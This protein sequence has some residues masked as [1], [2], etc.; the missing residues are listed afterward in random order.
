M[1]AQATEVIRFDE[2]REYFELGM[3]DSYKDT[4]KVL[5]NAYKEWLAEVPVT[6]FFTTDGSH[7]GLGVMGEKPIGSNPQTDRLYY[8][9]TKTYTLKTYGMALVM[10]YEVMRWDLFKTFTP[11][12]KE[13]AKTAI[14]RYDLVAYGLWNNAFSTADSVYTNYNSEAICST[15][16]ARM[17]SG[18]WKNRPTTDI[19]LSTTALQTATTDIRKTVNNRGKFVILT[20]RLLITTVENEWLAKILLQSEY[21]PD[22][23]NMQASPLRSYG[24]KLHTSPYITTSTYWFVT[25]DKSDYR[26]K[27]GMGDAP[28]LRIDNEPGTRNRM[29]HSYCSFR[30]QTYESYG[31][32][33]STGV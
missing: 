7:S 19:G 28:D 14:T 12:G 16:H 6:E 9:A 32:Y 23:A 17:D 11:L 30:M 29:F 3:S 13:L 10:Q 25:C 24:L 20:P 8:G 18:T 21:N 22:N 2:K 5:P 26:I 33:G 1:A 15:S 4:L 27:M 31:T